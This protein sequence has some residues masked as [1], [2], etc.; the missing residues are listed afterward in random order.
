MP[1]GSTQ[2]GIISLS[3]GTAVKWQ[4]QLQGV[5]GIETAELQPVDLSTAKVKEISAAK[6]VEMSEYITNNSQ[7][8]VN[9]FLQVGILSALNGH[10]NENS[11][12]NEISEDDGL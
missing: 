2:W 6:L 7:F 8:L 9:G 3:T 1:Q 5:S 10:E 12:D 11:E 4:K